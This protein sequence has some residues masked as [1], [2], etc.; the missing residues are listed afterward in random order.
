MEIQQ[1]KSKLET[2][3]SLDAIGVN[4]FFVMK[5]NND[6]QLRKAD[7]RND[8]TNG[9]KSALLGNINEIIAEIESNDDLRI[10]NLSAADDRS[11]VI[12]EYDLDDKP[13]FFSFFDEIQNNRQAGYF[14]TENGNVFEF[15]ND[16]LSLVDGYILRLGDEDSFIMIYRKNF[17][18]N[19]FKRDKI[20]LIKGDDTQFTTM[21][22]DFLRIDAKIDFFKIDNS[23]FIKNV[24][25]LEKFCEFEQIIIAEATKS[26]AEVSNLN[27]VD[28]IEVLSERVEDMSFARKL[29]RISTTSPVFTLP[30]ATIIFFAQNH[31]LLKKAFKYSATGSIILD[32]KKSQ[33]LFVRLLNDDFLHS[34]LTNNDY[35]TPSKDKLD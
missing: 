25:I 13:N 14:S 6:F 35:I 7:I 8:A 16:R 17:P 2:I 32:T 10:L 21:K 23:V 4:V 34:E 29:T 18:V 3:A 30:K 28:N 15:A 27:L 19:V 12:Y 20:Y 22:D 11:T 33:N 24:D 9:L 31:R 1:L 26:I 5:S